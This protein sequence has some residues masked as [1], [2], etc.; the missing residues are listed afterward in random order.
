MIRKKHFMGL[1]A[2]ILLAAIQEYG[3]KKKVTEN[4][5]TSVD[6]I[7]KY[8]TILEDEVG[9]NLLVSDTRG[10]RLTARA[11]L[12]IEHVAFIE[13]IFTRIYNANEK[14]AELK[15]E[16]RI[17][18]P[19]SVFIALPHDNIDNLFAKHPYINMDSISDLELPNLN[20]MDIDI[21]LTYVPPEGS[22]VVVISE[23]S[24][25]YGYFTSSKYIS[26]HGYPKDFDDL[27]ENHWLVNNETIQIYLKNWKNI[28]KQAQ[29]IRYSSK[30]ASAVIDIVRNGG[31]ITLMLLR[32]KE[33]GL[34]FL[35]NIPY[36]EEATVYLVAKKKTKDIP[37]VRAVIDYYKNSL[38]RM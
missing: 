33:E 22:D 30:S 35:D 28:V 21:G 16:V 18:M 34:I 38:S 7:N 2:L 8:L 36:D 1:Q 31:G 10:T 17:S 27:M 6:T 5:G 4:L 26:R 24:V 37:R 9:Y 25:K 11:Q 15:G 12:L 29:C 23:K 32:L 19:L 3:G 14:N 20:A 13:D